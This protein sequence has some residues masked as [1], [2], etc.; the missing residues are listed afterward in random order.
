MERL[1]G[2]EWHDKKNEL[3]LIK[4]EYNKNGHVKGYYVDK[5]GNKYTHWLNDEEIKLLEEG[6]K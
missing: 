4:Y 3:T 5:D 1:Q 6:N 2:K